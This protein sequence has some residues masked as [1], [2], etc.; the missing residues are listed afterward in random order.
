VARRHFFSILLAAVCV[1]VLATRVETEF[2]RYRYIVRSS[3]LAAQ[4][5]TVVVALP[6]LSRLAGKPTAI[7]LRLRGADEPVDVNISLDET[8]VTRVTVPARREVRV[9]AATQAG[10][11]PG[12]Q[13]ILTGTRLGWQLA[14]VEVGNVYGFSNRIPQF[15]IVPRERDRDRGIPLWGLALFAIGALLVQPKIDWPRTRPTRIVF[16]T[17]AGLVMALFA[18]TLFAQYFTAYRILLLLDTFILCVAVLYAEPLS[19]VWYRVQPYVFRFVPIL[20]PYLPHLAVASVVLWG[21]GQLYRPATG[22]TTLI[23][24]GGQFEGTALPAVRAVPHHIEAGAGYDGQFY[25]QLALDPFLRSEEITSAVDNPGYR[26]RRILLPWTAYV[27]GLGQPWYVLQVF[28][29]LNVICWLLLGIVLFRWLPARSIYATLAWIAIMFGEGLLAS[30]RH[31]LVDGPSMLLLAL[32]VRAVEDNRR[33]M[34]TAI[35]AAS[36]LARETN[37]IGSVILVPEKPGTLKVLILRAFLVV[38]PFALWTAYLWTL[39]FSSDLGARNFDWPAVAYFDK[40][41][42]AV[43]ALERE[44]WATYAKF[45]VFG[46][47]GL[48]TQALVLIGLRKWRSAW[49]RLGIAYVVLMLFIGP[50]V[51][52]GHPGAIARVLIPMT[53]AFNVLLPRN[54]WFLPLWALGNLGI[55]YGFE[56]MRLPWLSEW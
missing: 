48:T 28:A 14:S 43:D 6:D 32:A 37:L 38:A 39:Q 15:V 29:L 33:G 41:R 8:P 16:R 24:F 21:V 25:A 45:S 5:P 49:W 3:S 2:R 22:F 19:R 30:M 10:V 42:V 55:F 27:L 56:V 12:Q 7:V 34:A 36:G 17:A 54:R 51:W 53:V 46:L 44:G 1:A 35:L 23:L 40:W 9:D 18:A 26:G 47:V 11:G 52:E 13:L 50:A 31:S 20:G 4:E